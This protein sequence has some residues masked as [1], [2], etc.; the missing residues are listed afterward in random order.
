MHAFG[1]VGP[2]AERTA[3]RLVDALDGRTAVVRRSGA[4]ATDGGLQRARAATAVRLGDGWRATGE[5][6][7][8]RGALDRLARDHEYAVAVGFPEA[9]VPQIA[10]GSA[11]PEEP[12]YEAASA[13]DLDVEAAAEAVAELEPHET[14]ESLVAAVK[15]SPEADRAGA[16]ATFTGRVRAKEGPD[17]PRTE[18]LEFEKY[19]GTADR[20]M[21]SIES[22]LIEREG[23]HAVRLHHRTGV[24][25]DGEDIV[26]V[27]VLAGHR[28]EAFRTVRDGIDRLKDE[29]PLFKKEVTEADSFW[30]HERE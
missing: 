25:P 22:D 20:R 13:D 18:Y 26:F 16:I 3:D 12:F 9:R 4:N 14:L 6:G 21:R 17:D 2:G 15:R 10:L 27:V 11:D 1:I 19:E 29:V 8:L 7:T 30:V 24:V 5:G 28:D 23:V